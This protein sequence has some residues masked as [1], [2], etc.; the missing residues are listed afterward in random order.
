MRM[1]AAKKATMLLVGAGAAGVLVWLAGRVTGTAVDTAGD[2]WVAVGLL[3]VAGLVL[4]SLHQLGRAGGASMR[5]F[6]P[7]AFL[8]GF[9]PALVV[10]GF[11]IWF[12]QPAGGWLVGETHGFAADLGVDGVASD[13]G[14]LWP[15]LAFGL[16][17]LLGLTLDAVPRV[18]EA[19][20]R[21]AETRR[22]PA[23]PPVDGQ[24]REPAPTVTRDR[25]RA[26]M[27]G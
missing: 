23:Y 27:P 6:S 3:G 22:V 25:E 10:G 21:E 26:G 1:F 24:T 15:V 8:I 9:V 17:A 13:L 16:G 14:Q 20:A 18:V 12:A 5:M 4:T 11:V 7:T 2:Y 19:D